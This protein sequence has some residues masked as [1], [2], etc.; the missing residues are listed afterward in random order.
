MKETN[1]EIMGETM[2]RDETMESQE[3]GPS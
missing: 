1:I 3:I 2:W